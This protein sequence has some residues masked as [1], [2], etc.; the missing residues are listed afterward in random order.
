[1]PTKAVRVTELLVGKNGLGYLILVPGASVLIRQN[2]V[3]LVGSAGPGTPAVFSDNDKTAM[4]NP[5]PTG[6][7]QGT[8]GVDTEGRLVVYLNPGKGYDVQA[9][10]GN[11]STTASLPDVGV[12]VEDVQAPI[13]AGTL[14]ET[15]TLTTNGDLLTRAGGV[16]SRITRAALAADAAFAAV[17]APVITPEFHGAVGDGTADDTAAVVAA[18]AAATALRSVVIGGN[19]FEP[20]ATVRLRG[21]YRLSSLS[22]QMVASCNIDGAEGVL[23][24]P[25]AYAG[26]VLLLGHET[27]GLL[28]QSATMVLPRITKTG[29]TTLPAGSVGVKVQNCY[30]CDITGRR[31][32]WFE[33]DWLFTGLGQ[34]TV[35]NRINLGRMD[36][37][38]VSIALIPG[39]GG[40]V[41]SNRF[42]GGGISQAPNTLDGGLTSDLRRAGWRHLVIDGS[43][44]VGTVNSNTFDGI[45]FEG[46]LSEFYFDIKHA[47][48]NT[49]QGS[50]RFE[51][52]TAARPTTLATDTFTNVG[53]GLAVGDMVVFFATTTRPGG[54]NTGWPYYV[55]SVP[56]ADTFKVAET[57]GGST[58]SFTSNGVGV[59][60]Y[61]PPRLKIDGT[62][63]S[64]YGNIIKAGYFSYPGPFD[65]RQSNRPYANTIEPF[66][67]AQGDR[68]PARNRII[69][70]TF[71]VNQRGY[72]S[73]AFVTAG[74]YCFDRWKSTT[75]GTTLTY[76]SAP[77]GQSVIVGMGGSIA[78]V[79][80]R[81]NLE[82]GRYTLSWKGQAQARVYNVGASAPSYLSSPITVDI[83]GTADVVVEFSEGRIAEVQLERGIVA[84]PFERRPIQTELMLCK[85]YFQ[86]HG[87]G[88]GGRELLGTGIAN[89]TTSAYFPFRLPEEM[90]STPTATVTSGATFRVNIGTSVILA[91]GAGPTLDATSNPRTLRVN[92]S[93]ASGLTTGQVATLDTGDGF[94]DLSAEL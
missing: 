61:S 65:V 55:S 27:S 77:Q 73:G 90:R 40:W 46:D 50:T 21:K 82:P 2:G 76:T 7:S 56:D 11:V 79:I 85:R 28:L 31:V 94:L 74:N 70:G 67:P 53:H 32:D 14:V 42:V 66:T 57:Y 68:M 24:A 84:T 22:S 52:G 8:A 54:M 39:A 48:N 20:R 81:A 59:I 92:V 4:T 43:A 10:V 93:V 1:M 49:W 16:P 25:A 63:G 3:A 5:V 80:E 13:E 37:A 71:R 35:Y 17:Y 51:Q 64:T 89:S 75:S 38:K 78:Q 72:V 26:V 47:S 83:D 36:L 30:D 86:R 9:T 62:G 15:A 88:S 33:T 58:V 18:F 12:D 29:A 45:S 44:G 41:N 23:I 87:T 91:A 34:G 69:N 60:Y 19:V 6:V